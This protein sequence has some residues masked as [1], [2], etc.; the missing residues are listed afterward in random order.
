MFDTMA[1]PKILPSYSVLA[2]SLLSTTAVQA[3]S[4][5]VDMTT[6]EM[7]IPREINA[8]VPLFVTQHVRIS[9]IYT[10]ANV[11]FSHAFSAEETGVVM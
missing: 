4:I 10:L 1:L 7:P 9:C 3:V 8:T 2:I 6:A 11:L 5:P